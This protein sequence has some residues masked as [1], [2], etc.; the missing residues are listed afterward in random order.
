M[1]GRDCR[2]R[3]AMG[4]VKKHLP[5]LIQRGQSSSGTGGGRRGNSSMRFPEPK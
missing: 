1:S 5:K 3:R 2:A 4:D